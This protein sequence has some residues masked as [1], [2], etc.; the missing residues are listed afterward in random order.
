MHKATIL[1]IDDEQRFLDIIT[2]TLKASDYKV[3]Q[4]L[5]GEMGLMVARKFIPDIIICDWEMPVMNGIEAIKILKKDDLTKDIPIIMATGVMTTSGNLT[6]ALNAGAVDYIRKP[7]DPIELVARINSALKLSMAYKEIKGKNL[8]ITQQFDEIKLLNATKDKF[9]S[10]IAHDLKSP[11]NVI[12]G[13]ADLLSNE[14]DDFDDTERKQYISEI[15]RSSKS[16]Y[17]LLENLLTWARTQIGRIKITKETFN[18]KELI[19]MSIE[20]YTPNARKKNIQLEN[21]ISDDLSIEIDKHTFTTSIGNMVNNAIKFTHDGG[22]I[23]IDAISNSNQIEIRI[24]D[25][26]IGMNHEQIQKLFKIEESFSTRGTKNERGTGLGLILCR[27]F[28][29]KNG[30]DIKVES[31]IN[32][33]STFIIS[34]PNN[35]FI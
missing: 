33:G 15:N 24:K 28:I 17:T 5:N 20:P 11:F 27:E 34:L 6:T 30:G 8:E 29:E 12:L 25:S 18:L 7:I 35:G 10:I 32:K 22:Q 26:G 23:V 4:A 9:F 31:E 3:I 14:Y 21:S 19:N 2:N 1:V 13:Y 16:T